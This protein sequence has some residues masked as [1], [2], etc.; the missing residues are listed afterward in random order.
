MTP[1][2]QSV[3]AGF[4]VVPMGCGVVWVLVRGTADNELGRGFS[5]KHLLYDGSER[6]AW[7]SSTPIFRLQRSF[8]QIPAA[9]YV[10]SL[11]VTMDWSGDAAYLLFFF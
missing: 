1:R 9:T 2:D 8:G 6:S 3:P 7:T 4:T 11:P 5:V 10:G